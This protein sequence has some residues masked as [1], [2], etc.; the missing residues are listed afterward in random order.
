M[1]NPEIAES[2]ENK[3]RTIFM[4]TFFTILVLL[5][6]MSYGLIWGIL[7]LVYSGNEM[8]KP[9]Y[10]I[11]CDSII[12]WD[13]ALYITQ[14]I[15]AGLHL[16]SSVFQLI[17]T[18]YDQDSSIPKYIMGFRSCLVYIA[19]LS[20]LIGINVAYFGHPNMNVCG[21][22]KGLNLAYII[23]EWTI[24]GSCICLVYVVCIFSIIFKK[25]K[26]N[27]INRI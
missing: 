8:A 26:K 22:L 16:I 15:S 5:L 6:S 20:I 23:C 17:T 27:E 2:S 7:F 18:S 9:D 4:G 12:S 25:K 1:D 14:F 24:L 21:D 3:V 13:K 19:G 10:D 11:S